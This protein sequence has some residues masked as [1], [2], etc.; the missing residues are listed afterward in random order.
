MTL[1]DGGLATGDCMINVTHDRSQYI[2]ICQNRRASPLVRLGEY[3]CGDG[4]DDAA[5]EVHGRRGR[6]VV[7]RLL[8]LQHLHHGERQEAAGK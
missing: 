8:L 1:R 3:P 5:D 7:H 4:A 2:W 6:R